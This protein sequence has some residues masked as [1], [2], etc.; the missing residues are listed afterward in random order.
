MTVYLL[1]ENVLR[2]LHSG[3]NSMVRAWYASVAET[4]LRISAMTFFEKRRGWERKRKADPDVALARLAELD[5]L[6]AA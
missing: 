5:A 3:G 4:D 2:E 6:E 1:D